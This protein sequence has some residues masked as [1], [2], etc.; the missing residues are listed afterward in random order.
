MPDE[1][2]RH[3]LVHR[4]SDRALRRRNK[5]DGFAPALVELRGA[6]G[7]EG[8]DVREALSI[9]RRARAIST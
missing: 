2:A 7:T 3:Q 4:A 6:V 9:T 5:L 1:Y 8:V